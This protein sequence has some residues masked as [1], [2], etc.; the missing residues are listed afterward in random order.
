MI[1]RAVILPAEMAYLTPEMPDTL[2][3]NQVKP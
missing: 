1:P 3:L 2:I